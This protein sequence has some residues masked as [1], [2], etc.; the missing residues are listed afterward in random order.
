[1]A[2]SVQ[3]GDPESMLAFYRRMLAWRK[4]RPALAK[5]SFAL[6]ETSDSLISY[7][8]APRRRRRSS[9]PSTSG[10]IRWWRRCPRASGG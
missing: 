2:V 8:R 7:V 5:G 9:A 6:Q 10:P 4:A 3:D 1:M